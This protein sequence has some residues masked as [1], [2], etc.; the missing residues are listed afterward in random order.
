MPIDLLIRGGT[1]YDGTGGEPFVGDV[2]VT[3]DEISAVRTVEEI[4]ALEVI[5]ATGLAV[6]PGFIN[7]LSHSWFSILHD[8]RSLGELKQGV[9][10]QVMGEGWSMGPINESMRELMLQM[11]GALEV[12]VEWTRLSEYLAHVEKRGASQNV[13]SFIGATT[14]RIYALGYENRPATPSELD[15]MKAFT[16]EEMAEGALGIGSALIYSPG[17]YAST[18]ELIEISKAASKYDGKYISHLRS[19]GNEFLESLGELLRIAREAEIP[20]EVWH[21][22]A[23]GK[24]NWDKI[25][26]VIEI[27]EEARGQGEPITADMYPYT[28]GA[29]SLGAAI[30]PWFH[31]GGFERLLEN[32]R[33]ETTRK[34]IR[35]AIEDSEAGWENL[36]KGCD[37]PEN[38]LILGVQKEELKSYEGKSLARIAETQGKDPI[39]CLMDLVLD[40]GTRVSAA[41]FMMSEDNVRKQMALPWV[42][43]GSDAL[44]MAPEGAF[45]EFQTHPRSYGTFARVLGHYVRDEGVVSMQEAIRRLTSLPA[46]TMGFERRGLLRE[47]YFA[48]IAIFDPQVID[49][50]SN[51]EN[52]HSYAIGVNHVIVNGKV[53]LRDGE[54]AGNLAGRALYGPGKR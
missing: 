46:E 32:I 2:A 24:N 45:L 21:L 19:E 36:Y 33:D 44:S 41:Y 38:I 23:A 14:L 52:P 25:D 54:F 27:I 17:S 9:T 39:E 7:M 53:A 10:T 42:S 20:S 35:L 49:D 15:V 28:A 43:F 22:K 50:T 29:T 34:Q 48:D 5:D 3:G 40:A 31:E 37:G 16:E 6:A 30:P 11:K 47:G 4:E 18:E 1:I 8:P 26:Q 51:Y 13:A 12:E